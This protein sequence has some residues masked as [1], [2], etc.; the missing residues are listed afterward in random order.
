MANHVQDFIN[1][2]LAA[3]E[4][5]KFGPIPQ[6]IQTTPEEF[7]KRGYTPQ[8]AAP[9]II[10]NAVN[11]AGNIASMVQSIPSN[12]GKAVSSPEGAK[13]ATTGFLNGVLEGTNKLVGEPYNPKTGQ[14]TPPNLGKAVANAADSPV[15][16]ALAVAPG[17]KIFKGQGRVADLSARESIADAAKPANAPVR[18]NLPA[19]VYGAGREA[20]VQSTVDTHVAGAT[21]GERYGNLAPTMDKF[22]SQIS[23]IMSKNPKSASLDDIM[24]DYDA[25][26]NSEGIYRTTKTPKDAV[27]KEARGYIEDLY[28]SAGGDTT[29]SPSAIPDHA[30]LDLKQKIG[31]D[32]N[33]I[34]KKIENG[35]SLSDRDKVI[36]VARK[37][38]DDTL[39]SLHPDVKDLTTQQS[40]LYDA[41]DSMYKAREDE[42]KVNQKT[43]D[44]AAKAAETQAN[45]DRSFVAGGFTI[46]HAVAKPFLEKVEGGV[47]KIK[48]GMQG[49]PELGKQTGLPTIG[50][51]TSGAVRTGAI[52]SIGDN[53]GNAVNDIS[54]NNESNH[55]PIV[56]QNI[57]DVKSGRYAALTPQ[58][59]LGTDQYTQQQN[60]LIGQVR[61][62]Q[63][64]GDR[65]AELNAQS[66]LDQLN[67]SWSNASP[68]R[69]EGVKLNKTLLAGNAA[70][71][72]I[73]QADPTI[74]NLN[75]SFDGLLKSSN[76]DYAALGAA[77]QKIQNDTGVNLSSAKTK[78]ALMGSLDQAMQQYRF[79]YDALLKQQSGAPASQN[80]PAGLQGLPPLGQS[81][82]V[83][84]PVH[85]NFDFGSNGQGLP[86]LG[87]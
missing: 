85:Y 64:S 72:A 39:S 17:P 86:P 33:S 25:N 84:T 66:Q 45:R 27:Q 42:V 10:G 30:L 1:G 83:G 79:T 52:E 74:F 57:A 14:V 9:K 87:Q 46:P 51:L 6:A 68:L 77:L 58:D 50:G 73:A 53:H 19:N 43:A 23:D 35:T 34:Y 56:P 44:D 26:L 75:G 4:V 36:L 31:Q 76:R 12:I 32:A 82:D 67:N 22:G 5:G 29:I 54:N 3:N 55:S 2:I 69:D 81:Q 48:S 61:A 15:S 21:A 28:H 8:N 71:G 60:Q 20:K 38:V 49:L 47:A 11:D 70:Y 65:N 78:E 40:H 13:N 41:T 37:T 7:A 59:Q 18:V 62:A 16:T 63:A 80:K 24:K